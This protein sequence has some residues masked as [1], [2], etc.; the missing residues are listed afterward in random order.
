MEAHESCLTIG[1][2][3][4][5]GLPRATSDGLWSAVTFKI[6]SASSPLPGLLKEK[7]DCFTDIYSSITGYALHHINI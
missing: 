3:S 1:F 6:A 4:T 5:A 7:I 2:V